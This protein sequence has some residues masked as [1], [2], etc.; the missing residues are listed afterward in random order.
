MVFESVHVLVEADVVLV[1]MDQ[2]H[3]KLIL[4]SLILGL[5]IL[6]RLGVA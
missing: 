2:I 3:L 6:G 1:A 4:I 5:R